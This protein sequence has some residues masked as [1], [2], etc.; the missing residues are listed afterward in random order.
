MSAT[1]ADTGLTFPNGPR[2]IRGS[3]FLAWRP[4]RGISFGFGLYSPFNFD[5]RWPRSF[6]AEDV[7]IAAKLNALTFRSAVAVEPLKGL[8]FSVALDLVSLRV[9]WDHKI[10]FDVPN[11]PLPEPAKVT[12]FYELRG[13]RVGLAAGVMWKALPGLQFG[14]RYQKSVAIDLTGVNSYMFDYGTSGSDLPAPDRPYRIL[15]DLLSMFYTSQKVTGRMTLPR[16][17]ACGVSLTPIRNLSL[18]F[19]LQWDRWSEFGQWTFT[20]VKEGG[21]LSP[22]FPPLYREFYGIEPN[23]G[24]QGVALTLKD[25]RK[26]MAGVEY[27]AG[28]WFAFRAGFARHGSS[29]PDGRQTPLYPDHGFS[30]Y[31]FGAGYEGPLFAIWDSEKAVSQLSL[32]VFVRYASAGTVTSALTDPALIYGAKRWVAGLGVGFIF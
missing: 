8:A 31:S 28:K 24:I 21:D 2:E 6:S 15:S 25:S 19:D 10:P 12:S 18:S 3:Q 7:S 13:H 30:V 27:R 32:D 1:R 16:E 20:S 9:G 14:A 22:A 29:V 23:Y 11:Y 4:A 5:S 26:L 17:I